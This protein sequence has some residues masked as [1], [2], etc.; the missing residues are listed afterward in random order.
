MSCSKVKTPEYTQ[1]S[2]EAVYCNGSYCY[3][4]VKCCVFDFY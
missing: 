1:G 4:D 2:K 3:D